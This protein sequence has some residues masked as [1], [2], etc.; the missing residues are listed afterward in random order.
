M[1]DK[2]R[3]DKPQ[4]Q[5]KYVEREENEELKALYNEEMKKTMELED[6]LKDKIDG[7]INMD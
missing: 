2:V 7:V 3:P 1:E 5:I 4:G 6:D